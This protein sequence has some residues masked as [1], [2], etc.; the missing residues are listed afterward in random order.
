MKPSIK[1]RVIFKH[2]SKYPIS[3]MCRFF[4]VSRSGYYDFVKGMDKADKDE[5]IAKEISRCQELAKKTYGYRRV[6]IW[7]LRETG[8]VINDKAV[9]RIM[10]KYTV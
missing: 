1:F 9:L 6:K 7:L 2:H 5:T 3:E 4:K 8:L 10:N